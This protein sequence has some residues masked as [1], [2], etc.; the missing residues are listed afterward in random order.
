MSWLLEWFDS[1]GVGAL[2]LAIVT[3]LLI[4]RKTRADTAEK[5]TQIALGLVEPVS[6]SLAATQVELAATQ[7]KLSDHVAADAKAKAARHANAIEH[8]TW[9]TTAAEQI[10]A[11][12][13]DIPDP[14]PLFEGG[15]HG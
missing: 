14:P 3:A 7:A 11:L 6:K 1:L 2:L 15:A 5:L 12:G 10:R 4:R 13:G 9:D 8:M